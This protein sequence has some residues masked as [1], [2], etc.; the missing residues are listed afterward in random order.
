[1]HEKYVLILFT[2]VRKKC[3]GK[4]P[5]NISSNSSQV[6][7]RKVGICVADCKKEGQEEREE[8]HLLL[9]KTE[10]RDIC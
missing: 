10:N 6:Q 2:T 8:D 5:K 4:S 3:Q 1:M 7:V 9:L